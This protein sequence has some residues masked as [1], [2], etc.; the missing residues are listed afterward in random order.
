MMNQDE[1]KPEEIYT[2]MNAL[3]QQ[4]QLSHE[5]RG[6]VLSTFAKLAEKYEELAEYDNIFLN[7]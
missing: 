7:F 1:V 4:T 3:L 6:L 2:T 5:T